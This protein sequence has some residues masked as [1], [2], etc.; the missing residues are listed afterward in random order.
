[1]GE[2]SVTHVSRP[3][4]RRV[5]KIGILTAA[6]CAVE[7]A[8]SAQTYSIISLSSRLRAASFAASRRCFAGTTLS[9]AW[10]LPL[11]EEI[12]LIVP[13][14]EWVLHQACAEAAAWPDDLKVAVNLS[15]VQFKK[16]NLP[17]MV[18]RDAREHG[19]ARGAPRTRDH[20]IHFSGGKQSQPRHLTPLARARRQHFDG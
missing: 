5:T 9:A 6:P 14:G 3:V 7:R 20:G 8:H 15:P 1:M 18:F 16:G 4:V 13:I 17:Q 2:L 12:G 10:W 19:T 11:A